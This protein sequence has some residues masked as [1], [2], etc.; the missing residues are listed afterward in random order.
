MA[1]TIH[2]CPAVGCEDG[3]VLWTSNSTRWPCRFCDCLGHVTRR[4]ILEHA[5]Q[6]RQQRDR[7]HRHLA[8]GGSPLFPYFDEPTTSYRAQCDLLLGALAVVLPA[9]STC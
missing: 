2:P 6:L 1:D 9:P 8:L 4:Q 5:A 3:F 7:H